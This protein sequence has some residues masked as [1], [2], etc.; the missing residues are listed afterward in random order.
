[1]MEY[2]NQETNIDKNFQKS[3]ALIFR[4][5]TNDM[6][7]KLGS[8]KDYQRI[9]GYYD[10]FLLVG[11]IKFLPFKF[12]GHKHPPHALHNAKICF[13]PYCQTAQTTN[14]QYL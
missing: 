12:D 2:I 14:L 5:C 4:K 8:H 1:M 6:N 7:S 10:V 9:R 11:A 13:Y 3:Y